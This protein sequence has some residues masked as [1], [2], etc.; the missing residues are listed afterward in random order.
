MLYIG[1]TLTI[2]IAVT[3]KVTVGSNGAVTV[4]AKGKERVGKPARLP[5]YRLR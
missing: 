3:I 5:S 4:S 1:L 2:V